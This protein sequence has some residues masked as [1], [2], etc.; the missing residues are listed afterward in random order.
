MPST[1][2]PQLERTFICEGGL[3]TDLIFHHGFELPHFAS[4]TLLDDD[5]GLEVL[6]DYYRSFVD[7][8]RRHG[9]GVVFET[10]TWRAS[11]DWGELLGYSTDALDDVNRRGV[12]LLRGLRDSDPDVE[13]VVSGNVGP[14]GDGYTVAEAMT[15]DEA[16]V[17]HAAQIRSLAAAG[18]DLITV[19]T[20]TYAAE[21]T[22]IVRAAGDVGLPVV[23]SFTVET[24]GR[25]P[26]GQPLADAIREV[27]DATEQAAIYFMVNCAHPTHF[28]DVFDAPGPWHRIRGVRVNASRLSHAE[29]DEA[30]ELDRGDEADLARGCIE[31]LDKLADVAVVGGCCGTD[32]AHLEAIGAAVAQRRSAGVSA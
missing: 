3:E 6:R 24:D 7:V 19:L 20:I 1:T 2:L 18:A 9:T 21:A 29:L 25:L 32:K 8:A 30:E 12:E 10:P 5:R 14:R 28:S 15:P 23:V 11:S 26:S 31:L 13:I 27:D 16:R 17:Y 4:F 22:G